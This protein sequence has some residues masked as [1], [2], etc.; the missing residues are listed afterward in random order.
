MGWLNRDCNRARQLITTFLPDGGCGGD[1]CEEKIRERPLGAKFS[2]V[3]LH[4]NVDRNNS[5]NSGRSD[6]NPII[7]Q[8]IDN[9][10]N[11]GVAFLDGGNSRR[12]TRNLGKVIFYPPRRFDARRHHRPSGSGHFPL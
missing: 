11:F 8:A 12:W 1:S 9:F 2:M 10:A 5:S 3:A 7:W 6:R 4:G